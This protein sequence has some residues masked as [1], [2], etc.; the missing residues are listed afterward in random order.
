VFYA[1]LFNKLY[2]VNL[3]DPAT[4]F[5]VFRRECLSGIRFKTDYFDLDWEIVAKL[6]KKGYIPLEVPISYKSRSFQEGKKIRFFRD[7]FLVLSAILR[8]RFFN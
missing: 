8:F 4:M 6:I 5:K 7:G 2:G 3:T 1:W